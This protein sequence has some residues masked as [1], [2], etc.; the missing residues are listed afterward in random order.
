MQPSDPTLFIVDDCWE[1]Q[2]SVVALAGSLGLRCEP[3]DSAEAFLASLAPSRS[4]CALVDFRL[5]GMNGLQLLQRLAELAPTLPAILISAYAD[6]PVAV[7]AMKCGA[8][9]VIEKPCGFDEL[10]EAILGALAY[11]RSVQS[12]QRQ[13]TALQARFDRLDAREREVMTLVLDGLPNKAIVGK[14]DVSPR[15]LNRIR[16]SILQKMGASSVVE[17]A[18]ML[19]GLRADESSG[20]PALEPPRSRLHY[21]L[22]S[23]EPENA[24]HGM[25]TWERRLGFFGT[26]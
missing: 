1:S 20:P 14:L 21:R 16:A 23:P 2:E 11:G 12:A 10:S 5:G 19:A 4:G 26:C 17:L 15:T 6:V 13:Q 24:L 3:F 7:Q 18:Q 25:H 8:Y 22:D 9:S